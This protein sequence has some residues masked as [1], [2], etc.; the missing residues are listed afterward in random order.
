[1]NTT[2]ETPPTPTSQKAEDNSY[3]LAVHVGWPEFTALLPTHFPPNNWIAGILLGRLLRLQLISAGLLFDGGLSI[4]E[5]NDYIFKVLV[6][7]P[8]AA[9][10]VVKSELEKSNL[11]A[12]SQI[13]ARQGNGWQCIHPSP[14]TPVNWRL[15]E[16]RFEL[17]LQRWSELN[18]ATLA[19]LLKRRK[20]PDSE[21]HS[22][23]ES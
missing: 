4:G 22:E 16:E 18:A 6:T 9:V 21:Q 11:L 13:A 12:H 3:N 8:E 14:D 5:L 15:D 7:D 20:G 17:E 19:A 10:A 23:Q 2:L 1:M